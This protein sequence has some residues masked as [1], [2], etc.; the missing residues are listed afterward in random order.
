[1]KRL[2]F[3]LLAVLAGALGADDFDY[4]LVARPVATDVYAFIGKTEDF[5]TRNGGNIVNT[6]FIVGA[7]GIVVIDTGPS[8]RYGQQMRQAIARV[9]A[10]P[11][12]LVINN[13]PPSRPLPRQPGV[14]RRA[15]RCPGRYAPGH[16]QRR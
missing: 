2:L 15:D 1:M 5:D 16:R 13:P 9:S 10:K 8:L 7:E 11:V 6:G 12:V 14:C 3:V 4:R